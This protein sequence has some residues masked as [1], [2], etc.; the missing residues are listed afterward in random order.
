MVEIDETDADAMI[1]HKLALLRKEQE[2]TRWLNSPNAYQKIELL[3]TGTDHP[4]RI[5]KARE[6]PFTMMT[7]IVSGCKMAMHRRAPAR[8]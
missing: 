5:T 1:A 2:K 4:K 3:E 7:G 6:L 8:R